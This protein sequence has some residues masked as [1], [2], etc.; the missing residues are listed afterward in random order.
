MSIEVSGTRIEVTTRPRVVA[1]TLSIGRAIGVV[2]NVANGLAPSMGASVTGSVLVNTGGTHPLWRQLTADDLELPAN[3]FDNSLAAFA[4]GAYPSEDYAVSVVTFIRSV[5]T[6]GDS[7]RFFDG[8]HE[9]QSGVIR[10]LT[11]KRVMLWPLFGSKIVIQG[12]DLGE[13]TAAEI[14]PYGVVRW[15]TDAD[16]NWHV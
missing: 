10:N 1:I 15:E 9:G 3:A 16:L 2:S 4:G 14:P 12:T 6:D 11:D 7:V 13:D 5:A 8:A